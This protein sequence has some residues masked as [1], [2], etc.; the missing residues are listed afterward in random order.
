MSL[1]QHI[2]FIYLLMLKAKQAKKE[3]DDEYNA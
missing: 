3:S 1:D 2:Y